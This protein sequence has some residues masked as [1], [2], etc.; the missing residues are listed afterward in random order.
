M[1]KMERVFSSYHPLVWTLLIG[2]G[3]SR[4][5][6]FMSLPFMAIYLHE[7]GLSPFLI[8]LVIGAGPLCATFGGFIG[9]YLSDRLGREKIMLGALFVWSGVFMGFSFTSEAWIFLML[10]ILNGL[11]S[12][13]FE[14]TGQALMADLTPQK[15]RR[16]MFGYRYF[17]INV[18]GALG[19]ILGAVLTSTSASLAFLIT[20]LSFFVY[21]L[22]LMVMMKRYHTNEREETERVTLTRAINVLR[23]DVKFRYFILGAILFIIGFSQLH[24]NL[25]LYINQESENAT[26]IYPMLISGNAIIVILLQIPLTRWTEKWP[27]VRNMTLGTSLLA[28]GLFCFGMAGHWAWFVIGLLWFTIGEILVFPTSSVFIDQLAPPALRGTYFG[29]ASFQRIG[30]FLGPVLGGWLLQYLGGFTMF[31]IISMCTLVAIVCYRKGAKLHQNVLLAK[32]A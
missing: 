23:K 15:M 24:S 25:S 22:A 17:A 31:S 9:G 3:F 10:N 21:M 13:F 26:W 27:V 28:L 16:R 6:I 4:I 29:A 18:G 8:G 20:G 2:T 11:C 32:S 14:P 5:A 19:P 30:N 7:Q 1:G 12:S